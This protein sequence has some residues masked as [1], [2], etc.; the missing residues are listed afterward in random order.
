MLRWLRADERLRP[1]LT[2]LVPLF[3]SVRDAIVTIPRFEFLAIDMDKLAL[4][5]I[6]IGPFL[7]FLKFFLFIGDCSSREGDLS[8]IYFYEL[9]V[10]DTSARKFFLESVFLT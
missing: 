3:R 1:L 7:L 9:P 4:C 5:D 10:G 8:S 6:V 2:R